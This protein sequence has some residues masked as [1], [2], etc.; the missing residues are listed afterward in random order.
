LAIR[1]KNRN[2]LLENKSSVDDA[3]KFTL[4]NDE[5]AAPIVSIANKCKRLIRESIVTSNEPVE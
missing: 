4:N 5:A 2:V 3:I 1:I